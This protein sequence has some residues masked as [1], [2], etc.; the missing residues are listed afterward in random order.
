[1]AYTAYEDLIR[2]IHQQEDDG[3]RPNAADKGLNEDEILTAREIDEREGPVAAAKFRKAV[4]DSK[5][6]K[7]D[8][9]PQINFA[10]L[11]TMEELVTGLMD[12]DEDQFHGGEVKIQPFVIQRVRESPGLK[13]LFERQV[14]SEDP[15]KSDFAKKLLTAV[16]QT[17]VGRTIDG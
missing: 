10:T 11:G 7:L 1:M 13:A 9:I 14:E 4:K 2:D 5:L 15:K 16:S 3:P 6:A 12:L 8:V 17:R